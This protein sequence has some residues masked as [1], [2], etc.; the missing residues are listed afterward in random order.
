MHADMPLLYALQQLD[1]VLEEINQNLASLDPGRDIAIK[2]KR[3]RQE[4]EEI[5]RTHAELEATAR[6]Q[7]LELRS[8]DERI[9]QAEGDLYSGRIRNPRE[10]DALQHDIDALKRT[11]DRMELQILSVWERLETQSRQIADTETQLEQMEQA[12]QRHL[13]RYRQIKSALEAKREEHLAMRNELAQRISP[14]ALAQYE[15]MR[16][17]LPP[18]T[19]VKV[20]EGACGFCHTLLTPYLARQ[21]RES[22]ELVTCESCGRLLYQEELASQ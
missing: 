11:R 10:L 17:R 2:L 20:V 5:K 21:L 13:V 22:S 1:D 14:S 7:E 4:L 16:K 9:R 19:V 18:P 15:T 6:D 8:L 12:Y 3:Q